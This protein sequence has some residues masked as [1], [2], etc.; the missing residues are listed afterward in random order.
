L[1]IFL[2]NRQS[3]T[4]KPL[5]FSPNERDIIT[6][7]QRKKVKALKIETEILEN[8]QAKLKVSI[9][10]EKFDSAKKRAAK[11]LS[12]KY[13]ISGFR[14]GKAPYAVVVKHLGE[15]AVTEQAIESLIDEIYPQAIKE[16]EISPYG[17]GSLEEMPEMDPPSF[18]FL[19][20]LAPEVELSDYRE[21]RVDFE[22]KEV[23]EDDVNK[24]LDNIRDSQASIEPVERPIAEGDMVYVVLS[25][26]R[27]GETDPEKKQILEERRYPLI[28]EKKDNDQS[29]EYPFEGFSRKLIGLNTG[30][31]KTLEHK[32]DDDHQFEDMRG[33]TG[34]YS[35]KI[36][37]VKGRTLPEITDE[38]AKTLGEYE[39]VA[40]LMTEIEKSL[41]EQNESD[42]QAAYDEKIMDQLLEDCKIKYPPQ[43]LEDEINNFIHDLEHQVANQGLTIDLYLQSRGITMEELRDEVRDNAESRM[44]RSLILMEISNTEEIKI[45]PED[46][47]SR[48]R[49]TLEEVTKY[50]S[51]QEA[52]RLSSG[53]NLQNLINRIA[54]DEIINSTLQ[55]IRDI[56]MGKEILEESEEEENEEIEAAPEETVEESGE[57]VVE[58]PAEEPDKTDT[59]EA[60]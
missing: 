24:V 37:E 19:V 27:K 47:D 40:A 42:Q 28:I 49:N 34:V 30:D 9:E 4:Y 12:K 50:Y 38:F 56:A 43:M 51:E 3:K 58:T 8:H 35:V 18:N 16:S 41:E 57:A 10:S 7:S 26:E 39:D 53:E 2:N 52:K 60:E 17:P 33:I 46:I 21:I 54:S 31:E 22:T 44:K 25:G 1:V 20:P 14:P 11:Q 6:K 23:T 36:E 5:I 59:A 48:V 32:F 29:T 55:R 45:S 13:K 15:G